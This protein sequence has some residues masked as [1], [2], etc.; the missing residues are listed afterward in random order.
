MLDTAVIY[1]WQEETQTQRTGLRRELEYIVIRI[2]N[3]ARAAS[4]MQI[5]NLL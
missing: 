4:R 1:I 3:K 5:S 2:S